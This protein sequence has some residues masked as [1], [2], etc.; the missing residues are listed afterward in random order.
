MKKLLLFILLILNL[1]TPALCSGFLVHSL[2]EFNEALINA[3]AGDE[4]IID[5]GTYTGW[6]VVIQSK[7]TAEKPLIIRARHPGMTLFTGEISAP[8]FQIKGKYVVLE[9]MVFKA[10]SLVKSN[11]HK[12]V[13]VELQ[14]SDY[15]RVTDCSFT[16][17]TAKEQFTPVL[18]IS[19]KGIYNKID[20]CSF[21]NNS[22]NQEVQVKI[23]AES[24]PQYTLIEH[25]FFKDKPKV[26]WKGF[27]GGECIQV[28]QDPVLLGTIKAATRVRENS[29]V[30]CNG[31][32]EVISNKSSGN[33]YIK[34]HFE[35]CDGEL[36]MR[37]GHDCLIDSNVF[38]G[39]GG[40]R[41]NGTGHTVIH[42]IITGVKTGIRLMYGMAKG[43]E[44]TGF[45]IAASDCRISGNVFLNVKTGILVGDSKNADWT[46]KFDT[47][48]YPSPVLQ[49][50]APFNNTIERNTFTNTGETVLIN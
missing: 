48:K 18:V 24:C 27:N 30:N 25:N 5:D 10:C 49:N 19:G 47:V 23:T 20:H 8:V 28:G 39:G 29:F 31:E 1:K 33:S 32:A 46:G 14:N 43:K 21:S 38:T 13:L 17:N 26:S 42:N 9:G 7:G 41:L 16:E 35:N 11:G 12:G 45:Y 37:G 44:E 6:S 15:C 36:V 3:A 2:K 50:I 22:D 34:N 40:I 4:L